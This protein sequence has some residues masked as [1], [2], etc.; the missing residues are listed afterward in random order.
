MIKKILKWFGLTVL[1]IIVG[2][3]S[4]AAHEWYAD[5]PFMFRAYM[6]R[7]LVKIAFRNPETLTS[8]GFLESMGI[9]GHNAQ[10]DD[11]HPDRTD[12]L[13]EEL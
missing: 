7:A 6:D 8:L 5:K 13:F 3:G 9:H 1:V 10:L 11:V 4:F 12:E 2:V